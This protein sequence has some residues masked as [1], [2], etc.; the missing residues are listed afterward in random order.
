MHLKSK[1]NEIFRKKA[2]YAI[3]YKKPDVTKKYLDF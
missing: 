3:D 1:D 2:E